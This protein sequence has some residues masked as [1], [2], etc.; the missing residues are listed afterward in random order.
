VTR[1]AA[2]LEGGDSG[3]REIDDR[4][5]GTLGSHETGD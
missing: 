2:M 4:H 5:V 1:I 3:F